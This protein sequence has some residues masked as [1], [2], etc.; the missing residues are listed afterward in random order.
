MK[1]ERIWGNW[2]PAV[3]TLT[4][5]PKPKKKQQRKGYRCRLST[6]VPRG[7]GEE[8]GRG[9]ARRASLRRRLAIKGD[10]CLCSL[11]P[12]FQLLLLL[13]HLPLSLFLFFS[14]SLLSLSVCFCSTT[15]NCKLCQGTKTKD[16]LNFMYSMLLL[17]KHIQWQQQRE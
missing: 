5:G 11:L 17:S 9:T 16:S 3:A 2:A 15:L 6:N 1:S 7:L 12:S 13:T 4:K 8:G 10:I 14:L